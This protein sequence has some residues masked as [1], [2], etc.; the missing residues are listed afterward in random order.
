[1]NHIG[2]SRNDKL[3]ETL[4]CII[5]E[6]C[7]LS[8]QNCTVFVPQ[9]KNPRTFDAEAIIDSVKSYAKCFDFVYRVCL[10]GG[11]PF[12]HKDFAHIAGEIAKIDNILFIDIVPPIGS[13]GYYAGL[14]RKWAGVEVSDYGLTSRK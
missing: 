1:M 7:N 5:T 3:S 9:N 10:M 13:T 2:L 8:C 4:T 14:Q 6:R 12:L 11:E